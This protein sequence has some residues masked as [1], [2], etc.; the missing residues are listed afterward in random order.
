MCRRTSLMWFG[1]WNAR[2]RSFLIQASLALEVWVC[3]QI[4]HKLAL[5][6]TRFSFMDVGSLAMTYGLTGRINAIV[7]LCSP[8]SLGCD[9]VGGFR[10]TSQGSGRQELLEKG[11][12]VVQQNIALIDTIVSGPSCLIIVY[13]L[14]H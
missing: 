11:K 1:T 2:A 10:G 8:S 14:A 9:S 13:V 12:Q 5:R 3:P 7:Y 6:N 4:L